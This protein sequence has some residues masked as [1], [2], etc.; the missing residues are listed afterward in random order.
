MANNNKNMWKIICNG[1]VTMKIWD[2][3]L[4]WKVT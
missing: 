3:K 2:E 1:A 4:I